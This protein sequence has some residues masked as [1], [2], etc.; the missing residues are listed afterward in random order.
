MKKFPFLFFTLLFFFA[1]NKNLHIISAQEVE[2]VKD[3]TPPVDRFSHMQLYKG[4]FDFYWDEEK[5]K[6]L[7][8]IDKL[9]TEFLYVNSLAAG[10]GS[11]DIGLDRGQLGQEHV[12][13]FVKVGPKILLV[14][15]NY[16]FRAESNNNAERKSVEEAFAQSV[17]WGFKV[18]IN[19]GDKIVVDATPFLLQDAHDVIGKL[20]QSNQGTY[21]LDPLRSAV[22]LPRCKAF[23]KNTELEATLTFTG[24]PAGAYIRQVTPSA[25]AVTVRQHHSFIELPD[26]NYEPRVFDPRSGYFEIS[27]QDYAT[28][29]DQPLVKRLITRHR[30]KKVNPNSAISEAVEPIVYYLDPGAPEPVRSALLDGARWWNQAFEAVGYKDAFVV[31]IL[32][33]DADPMDVRYNLIQWIHRATRGWSYGSSVI[34]PRT[35]EIIKGHVS[36]GS[37]RVRQDFLIA[38]GLIQPYETGKPASPEIEKMALARLRQLSAH[39]VGHT[40]G[41]AHNFAASYNDRASVMDYP[42]PFVTMKNDGSMDFSKAYD[43]KIG[44]WDKRTVLY[45]YQD[46][47]E[48]T[49][50]SKAL[51]DILLENNQLGLKYISDEDARPLGG[52]HPY[53][54]LWDNGTD[55]I[56]EFQ[57]LAVVREKALQNFGENNIPANAP[58][59]TLE[60][61]LVPL[62]LSHRYQ[63]EAVSKLIGGVDYQY[64]A[65]LDGQ[66]QQQLVD[67][68]KQRAALQVLL[69]SIKPDFLLLPQNI[70]NV[71]PPKPIGYSRTRES[72]KSRTGITF[73]PIA[74][75]ESA[76]DATLE[77]I[78]HP[79]RANRLVQHYEM[80]SSDLS[81]LEV[82]KQLTALGWKSEGNSYESALQR[83]C[84]QLILDR[85]MVLA[86]DKRASSQTQALC[87]LAIDNLEA[88]FQKEIPNSD[89]RK[90]HFLLAMSK[91]NR[92]KK[93]PSDWKTNPAAEMPAGSPIGCSH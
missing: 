66:P 43:D 58:M 8:N 42:Y 50:V 65:R 13:K 62:Y 34:D 78:L 20:K 60:E 39:E 72:F 28:P 26:D 49:N 61:V 71:I 24:T 18:E 46:F 37:L 11:N 47:P 77:A 86:M 80:G 23:P 32:P 14:Q 48:G 74:I 76:V 30:L 51:N 29:I 45:G 4:Y 53:A 35:G 93:D 68:K 91:I 54:H 92:F 31:K 81:F 82:L 89:E 75:A 69:E 41:L 88:K 57:R 84:D 27:Y 16:K 40:I 70:L 64:N 19:T 22:F 3:S 5:G 90:A 7:L 44:I 63:M 83:M 15:M 25:N 56:S 73:D 21:K 55:A 1:C 67:D 33:E 9:D 59:A 10:V 52:A 87:L 12:V 85:I 6:I 38:Q 17:L 36:L 2:S 79:Q